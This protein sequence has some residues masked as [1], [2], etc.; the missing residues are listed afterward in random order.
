VTALGLDGDDLAATVP[1]GPDGLPWVDAG[2]ASGTRAQASAVFEAARTA[3]TSETAV[4]TADGGDSSL[5]TR[6]DNHLPRDTSVVLFSP[7]L[8][9]VP[10][11]VAWGLTIRGYDV[12]LVSPNVVGGATPG[13]T[14]VGIQRRVRLARLQRTSLTGVDWDPTDPLELTLSRCL[15]R[16]LS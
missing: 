7:L 1:T 3:D 16:F 6:L 14:L 11:D 15:S 10:V 12:L 5:V 13:Q 8:D 4:A 9:D 2:T